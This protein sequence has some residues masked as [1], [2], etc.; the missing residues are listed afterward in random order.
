MNRRTA[1]V[2]LAATVILS[3]PSLVSAEYTL[4]LKNG[5][6]ITVQAYREEG[7]MIKFYGAG[8]EV[9]IPRDQI[10]SILTATEGEGRGLDLRGAP[11]ADATES[12]QEGQKQPARP[13]RA[14]PGA[15]VTPSGEGSPA[16]S[17]ADERAKE[18]EEYRRKVKELTENLRAARDRYALATRGSTSP[19]PSLPS[20][21]EQMRARNDDLISRLRD[22]QESQ[23][24]AR[25]DTGIEPPTPFPLSGQPPPLLRSGPVI[26]RPSVD[27]RPEYTEKQKELSGLR[28]QI[29]QLEKDRQ[30]LIDE[31]RQKNMDT[32]SLFLE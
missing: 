7:Q 19:D 2:A 14:E 16:E 20:T 9:G 10:Q 32:G 13:Q 5:R 4:V 24:R 12:G 25:F 22:V 29:Y 31:M 18:E 15:S 26:E 3:T 17:P 23:S 11:A 1:R 28:D 27:V 8:G 30:R 21:D 6:R